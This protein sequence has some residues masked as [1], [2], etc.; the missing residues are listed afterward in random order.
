VQEIQGVVK[1]HGN[2]SVNHLVVGRRRRLT[3]YSKAKPE[4]KYSMC[5]M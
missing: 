5:Q 4:M 3:G 2:M 1:V